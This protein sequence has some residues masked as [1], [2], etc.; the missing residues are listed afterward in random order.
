MDAAPATP[1]ADPTVI[2]A[3]AALLIARPGEWTWAQVSNRPEFD[4]VAPLE[5]ERAMRALAA[6]GVKQTWQAGYW[7]LT[8]AA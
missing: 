3:V 4:E 8:T 7:G 2:A 6:A 1:A 5:V